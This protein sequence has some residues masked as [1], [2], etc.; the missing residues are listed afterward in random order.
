MNNLKFSFYIYIIPDSGT[1]LLTR[2]SLQ[3]ESITPHPNCSLHFHHKQ[4]R[5]CMKQYQALQ[6]PHHTQYSPKFRVKPLPNCCTNY[7]I[8]FLQ[9]ENQTQTH[10]SNM[11][12]KATV[13]YQCNRKLNI[14]IFKHTKKNDVRNK[15]PKLVSHKKLTRGR[16]IQSTKKNLTIINLKN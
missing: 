1:T 6:H 5:T 16:K 4:H 14:I 13:H 7:H 11:P 2:P 15:T 12:P 3:Q 10:V 9:Q 8:N